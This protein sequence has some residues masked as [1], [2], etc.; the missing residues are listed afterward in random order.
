MLMKQTNYHKK[1]IILSALILIIATGILSTIVFGILYKEAFEDRSHQ[2]REIAQ[3]RARIIEA[4]ARA[5]LKQVKELAFSSTMSQVM[6]A[7]HDYHGF[8]ETGELV[9]AK[10]EA[11]QI[12]FLLRHQRSISE[13][14][15][16]VPLQSKL[17]EP[18]RRAL[19]EQSGIMV[20][21]DYQ[22]VMVL[23]AYEPVSILNLGI[24]AKIN[25]AEIRAPF[26]RA[27]KLV[28]LMT[29]VV[30]SIGVIA[31]WSFVN[32]LI[33][34]MLESETRLRSILE[35]A[36]MMISV[37]D[38][39]GRYLLTNRQ[40]QTVFK[41]DPNWIIG[42]TVDELFPEKIAHQF[43]ANN[44]LV[45][46]TK[47]PVVIEEP[48]FHDN[49]LHTY[50]SVKFPIFDYREELQAVCSI[51][52]DITQQKHNEEELTIFKQF[53]ETS[54]EGMGIITLDHRVV[55]LNQALAAFI[56]EE[57]NNLFGKDFSDYYPRELRQYLQEEILP[58]LLQTGQWSGEMQL[59]SG[60]GKVTHTLENYFLISGSTEKPSYV[61]LV[62]NDIS[63]R[64]QM[65]EALRRSQEN[66]EKAQQ[67]AHLGSWE[68]NIQTGEEIWSRE[69]YRIFG[70]EPGETQASY[71]LFLNGLHPHDKDKVFEAIDKVLKGKQPYHLEFRIGLPNHEERT[72][73]AQGE[74]Y[75]DING[76]P[77][78]M[79]GTVLDITERKQAEQRLRHSEEQFRRMFE[80]G[81][82]GMVIGDMQQRFIKVNFAFCQMLGY[83]ESELLQLKIADIS[84]P[85]DISKNQEL[86]TLALTGQI[87]F[88]Q[89][90]KR[91]LSKDGQ[92]IWGHLAASIFF[93][94]TGQPT[95][96]LA[97]IED[98]TRRKQ[99]EEALRKS[100]AMLVRAQEIAHL[101]IWEW[102]L[103]EDKQIWSAEN[104]RLLGHE[105][106]AIEPSLE[107]FL[108]QV[109]PED[110]DLIMKTAQQFIS[111]SVVTAQNHEFRI[112]RPDHTERI[113]E[114]T[115]QCDFDEQGQP[116]RILGTML[117][118]T[119]RNQIE[120]A[121]TQA[122]IAADVANQAKSEF[123]AN[124]SHEIRTPLNAVIGFSELLST[125]ITDSKSQSYLSSIQ[126]A[127]KAL[128]TL[129]NDILDLSK[130][131]AGQLEIQ[132][133]PTDLT[134]IINELK[135]LF[136]LKITE[137]GLDFIVEV[138]RTLPT[139]LVLD[140]TRLRQVLLNL[141][142]N[143][144]KFTEQGY[145]KLSV[146]C[147]KTSDF[148]KLDLTIAVA[149]TGIGI[150][151]DQQE[152]I[153]AAFQQQDGQSNRQYGGTGLG[154]A[155][156]KRLTEMMQGQI[157]IYS[158]ENQGSIFEIT[159]RDVILK[160]I[161]TSKGEQPTFNLENIAFEPGQTVLIVDDIEYN[162][163][164][165]QET[166]S[167]V[168]LK[169]IEAVDGQ[170]GLLFAEEYQPDL[171]LMDIRM[172]ILSGYEAIKY[173]KANPNTQTI[174][175]I[176]LT[177]TAADEHSRIEALMFDRLLPKPIHISDLLRA[178][179]YYLK[180]T[181]LS[182]LPETVD[183]PDK[184]AHIVPV[185]QIN[186]V[187]LIAELET[188]LLKWEAIHDGLDLDKIGDFSAQ[189]KLLGEKYHFS[190][191]TYYGKSLSE[192]IQAFNIE[193]IEKTLNQFPELVNV[194]KSN[195][196]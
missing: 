23:A 118:I 80:D 15:Q 35:H 60:Q 136:S 92:I 116:I 91:Y 178:I 69:Q 31:F 152:K 150:P 20:G 8:D 29:I 77:I 155:I 100:E 96:F 151:Q 127:G 73:F 117:D 108:N 51:S 174:P 141:I 26:I 145:V 97:K 180:Y 17:A 156:T 55:Y 22:N 113:I 103:A 2:L 188:G 5:E 104:Y 194:L 21:L 191:L 144:V 36:P 125:H 93:D 86:I 53:V 154:L 137:K 165:I 27:I 133:E 74:V 176:A 128:L 52:T 78:R 185:N 124:M 12:V 56:Q 39:Q 34:R 70:Y 37:K 164:L 190:Y 166:L 182:H 102:N 175:V 142:G 76:K 107:N 68:W 67:I 171:I 162:R 111:G 114:L 13:P 30:T 32:P 63:N 131:E 9:I 110:R 65:E 14:P 83:T 123:L 167:Q 129:I 146:H 46:E 99:T 139:T 153:F 157:S 81:P 6:D 61:A 49:R 28:L 189:I 147:N 126:T 172:P 85:E 148:N 120:A 3:S 195:V 64:K 115:A 163:Q 43:Q 24:V 184:L 130:I 84:Y 134:L 47:E 179:S 105:P 87:P 101:G 160:N 187:E 25:L 192:Y 54:G 119:E 168:H 122:K 183:Q 109:Y 10:R 44:D 169:V 1:I 121:L 106:H 89:M 7:Y 196:Q 50:L 140:E 159:L 112:I 82:I 90:E 181:T 88:Y 186:G 40:H 193:Q 135:Q 72:V 48:I 95:H 58:Q 57:P 62:V 132:L 45:Q 158:Q 75:R 41:Y 59:I 170:Q 143:A 18:M 11:G 66:L 98:I 149:D 161:V 79:L 173:L 71:D 33:I 4:I 177:A 38:I 94:E 19:S 42:K 138:D 16:S